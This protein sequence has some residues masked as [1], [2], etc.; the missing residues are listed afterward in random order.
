MRGRTRIWGESPVKHI[1]DVQVRISDWVDYSL[2][3]VEDALSPLSEASEAP[4]VGLPL[5][6]SDLGHLLVLLPLSPVID[7]KEI[8]SILHVEQHT[9]STNTGPGLPHR[10]SFLPPQ[11]W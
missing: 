9:G 5:S 11:W 3:D 2:E 8:P 1:K 7:L 6:T 10:S 4:V